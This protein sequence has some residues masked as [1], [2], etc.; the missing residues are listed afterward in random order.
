[1]DEFSKNCEKF[2]RDVYKIN[3]RLGIE[4]YSTLIFTIFVIS[5]IFTFF[6]F[7]VTEFLE[8]YP[9]YILLGSAHFSIRVM[10]YVSSWVGLI[11]VFIRRLHDMDKTG[12][13]ILI[14]IIMGFLTNFY[15]VWIV[16]TFYLGIAEGSDGKNKYGDKPPEE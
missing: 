11:C 13:K 12:W 10:Y 4:R 16:C 15:V 7:L 5:L 8:Y 1:M 6:D 2:L 14:P 3:G 9:E